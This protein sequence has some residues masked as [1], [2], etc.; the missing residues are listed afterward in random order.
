MADGSDT[1]PRT[2]PGPR[3]VTNRLPAA[4]TVGATASNDARASFSTDGRCLDLFAPGQ[5]ITSAW[6]TSSTATSAIRDVDG[7]AARRPL[8]QH[9]VSPQVAFRVRTPAD[10][11]SR[12]AG[13]GRYGQDPMEEEPCARSCC[14]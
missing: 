6:W 5:A 2:E 3:A 9:L 13:H 11:M 1:G 10:P 14:P 8:V 7:G 12:T 4:L